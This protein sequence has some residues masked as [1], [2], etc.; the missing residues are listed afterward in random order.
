MKKVLI[1]CT[2]LLFMASVAFGAT[3]AKAD[4]TKTLTIK[5]QRVVDKD[6][7]TCDRC[8]ATEQELKKAVEYLSGQGVIVTVEEVKMDV[9]EFAKSC[10]ESNRIWLNDKP[11]EEVLEAK[12]GKSTCSG[13]C[14]KHTEKAEC[15]TLIFGDK[16]YESVPA[17]LIAM[18]GLKTLEMPVEGIK[19]TQASA[20]GCSPSCAKTCGAAAAKTCTKPCDSKDKKKD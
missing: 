12:V 3:V 7:K 13:I 2:A 15:R 1:F 11:L 8:G 4:A 9:K 5:W 16:T 10:I 19:I 14:E 18:A 17:E 6:G 20:K